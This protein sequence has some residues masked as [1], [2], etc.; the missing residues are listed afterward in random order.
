[1]SAKDFVTLGIGA[2]PGSTSLFVLV[3]LKPGTAVCTFVLAN[4][5]GN[6]MDGYAPLTVRFFD[7]SA[8]ATSWSWSFGDGE[9]STL[10]N[11]THTY[12]ASG[13]YTVTLTING[14]V[15]SESRASFI[16]VGVAPTLPLTGAGA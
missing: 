12:A 5:W 3:G 10:E 6:N 2:S 14:G 15:S 13:S 1:M 11:P 8:N 7:M 4:F 16:V 9:S